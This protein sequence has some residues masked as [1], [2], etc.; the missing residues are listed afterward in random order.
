MTRSGDRIN[1][2]QAKYRM[3]C[4]IVGPL[5][6]LVGVVCVVTAGVDFFTAEGMPTLFWLG[7]VGMPL[8][9]VGSAL[10]MAGF[11]GAVARFTAAEHAPVAA[12]TF[13]YVAGETGEGV[14]AVASAV[15]E[16]LATGARR[17]AACGEGNDAGAKFCD[18]CGQPLVRVCGGC[19]T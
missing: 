19:Q 9:F 15:R 18:A 14:R 8:L 3:V 1:P 10:A 6:F 13:N 17:C 2:G 12:D 5:V 4:R 11:M 16:G 7:F